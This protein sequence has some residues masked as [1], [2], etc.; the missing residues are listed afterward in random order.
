M[1]PY[2][3]RYYYENRVQV[4]RTNATY[5][6]KHRKERNAW[7]RA[8]RKRNMTPERLERQRASVRR[9]YRRNRKAVLAKAKRQRKQLAK[10]SL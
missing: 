5:E 3:Q 2:H 1:I 8:W 10:T 6:K 7:K 9:W 4:L